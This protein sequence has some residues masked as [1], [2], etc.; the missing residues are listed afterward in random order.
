MLRFNKIKFFQDSLKSKR[1]LSL[2]ST[3]LNKDYT[4]IERER[5]SKRDNV[6]FN[7]APPKITEV[8]K[9]LSIKQKLFQQI[10]LTG[11]ISVATY[12]QQCN[13]GEDRSGYYM[14]RDPLGEHGDFITSPEI[15][16]IFGELVGTWCVHEFMCNE[17]S[18]FENVP[19]KI[20]ELGPGKGTMMG[21]ILRIISYLRKYLNSNRKV[22]I[23]L[24]EVSDTLKAKQKETFEKNGLLDEGQLTSISWYDTIDEVAVDENVPEYILAHEFFDALPIYKVKK[25]FL[26]SEPN[27]TLTPP[28]IHLVGKKKSEL[29]EILIDIDPK[30]E[31]DFRM[32]VAANKTAVS[33]M[34]ETIC[35]ND[36]TSLLGKGFEEFEVNFQ[37][38]AIFSQLCD[39][40]VKT[41]GCGL[42][43]DY[44]FTREFT[45][46]ENVNANSNATTQNSQSN[47]SNH[48]N[49]PNPNIIDTFRGY[50][51]HKMHDPL[52]DSGN[53]D[54]T[55]DV[56][57]DFLAKSVLYVDHLYENVRFAGPL[58]QR[59]FLKNMGIDARLKSL[60]NENKDSQAREKILRGYEY[61]TDN[62]KMGKRFKVMAI[63]QKDRALVEDLPMTGFHTDVDVTGG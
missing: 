30:T 52:K 12:M 58:T 44:G 4:T 13:T 7:D 21:D 17:A 31:N 35:S 36:E 23:C 54:L 45:P 49:Q 43:M 14:S 20:I 3:R 8:T 18:S 32:V 25:V 63:M 55:A 27:D 22:E 28:N 24:V 26:N 6:G 56:D 33:S 38:G 61:M 53:V 2:N 15:S 48:S 59:V 5:V 57:F 34:V 9:N 19:L 1:W 16:Q 47:Q 37:A 11:P 51:N 40:V 62:E 60:L 41:G 29:R 46:A 50:K 42:V 10:K 39:R